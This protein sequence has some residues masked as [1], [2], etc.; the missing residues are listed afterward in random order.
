M[1]I[2]DV[3][4]VSGRGTVVIGRIESGTIKSGDEVEIVGNSKPTKKAICTGVE[5]FKKQVEEG[6]TGNQVGILLRGVK[7][8]EFEKGQI[9]AAPGTI[10]G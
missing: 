5:A 6:Q 4:Y 1:P 3:S 10:E 9:L 7:K 2:D 8:E